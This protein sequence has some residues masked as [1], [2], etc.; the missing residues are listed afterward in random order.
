MNI[1]PLW[2]KLSSKPGGKW[3][4][5]RLL[6]NRIPYSGSIGATILELDA[7][8]A[9]VELKDRRAVRN[10]LNSIHAVALMN[11]AELT[12]GL[13]MVAG[14]PKDMRAILT[15][16][17]ITYEKKARGTIYGEAHCVIPTEKVRKEY[18]LDVIIKNSVGDA[19]CRAQAT[20]LIGPV[21]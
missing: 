9:K 13:S 16:F 11:L 3:L 21:T 2:K 19:L 1:L 15:G 4:F 6:A 14:L 18:L 8:Y 12:S 20:W 5:S 10:H 17:K 7:G